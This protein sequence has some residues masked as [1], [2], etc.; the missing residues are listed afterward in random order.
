MRGQWRGEYDT[1]LSAGS[2]RVSPSGV[3]VCVCLLVCVSVC[4]CLRG[5]LYLRFTQC[6]TYWNSNKHIMLFQEL[7]MTQQ[8]LR[9]ITPSTPLQLAS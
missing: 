8:S 2:W 6:R 4:E 9:V 1:S 5:G 3:C 7:C